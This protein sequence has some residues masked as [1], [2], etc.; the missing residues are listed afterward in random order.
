MARADLTDIMVIKHGMDAYQYI[1][2]AQ[3]EAC[4]VNGIQNSNSWLPEYPWNVLMY[5]CF[6]ASKCTVDSPIISHYCTD[7]THRTSIRE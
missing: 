3:V 6:S 1:S 2:T 5:L 4:Q 7:Y